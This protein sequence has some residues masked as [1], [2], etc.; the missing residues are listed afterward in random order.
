[1]NDMLYKAYVEQQETIAELR[2]EILLLRTEEEDISEP[3]AY[4]Q[5]LIDEYTIDDLEE[6]LKWLNEVVEYIDVYLGYHRE[7]EE[8][9]GE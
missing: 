9:D 6:K 8:E 2:A 4:A 7:V 3:M 1:M 5:S